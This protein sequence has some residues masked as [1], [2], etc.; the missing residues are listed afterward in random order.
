MGNVI[1]VLYLLTVS[2][3]LRDRSTFDLPCVFPYNTYKADWI[4]YKF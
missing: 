3:L 2:T 1:K 4:V